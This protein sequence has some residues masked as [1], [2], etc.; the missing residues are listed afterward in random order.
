MSKRSSARDL[1]SRFSTAARRAYSSIPGLT[2]RNSVGI[3]GPSQLPRPSAIPNRPKSKGTAHIT[4]LIEFLTKTNFDGQIS[5]KALQSPSQR[6]VFSIFSHIMSCFSANF[7]IPQEKGELEDYFINTLKLF[8][9]PIPL[10]RSTVQTPGAPH[11]ASQIL[12]S[13]DWLRAEL[14]S[15][16]EKQDEIF[17]S[18]GNESVP[19]SKIIF[20]M[21]RKC[22]EANSPDPPLQVREEFEQ[23]IAHS[24]GCRPEDVD[25]LRVQLAELSNKP[26]LSTLIQEE[27]DLRSNLASIERELAEQNDRLHQLKNRIPEAEMKANGSAANLQ[28]IRSQVGETATEVEKLENLIASQRA[29]Y[30]DIVN[31]YQN[32]QERYRNRCA[33]R[34]DLLRQL[35]GRSIELVRMDKPVAPALDEYN[36]LAVRMSDSSLPQLKMRTYLHTFDALKEIPIIC[37]ELAEVRTKLAALAEKSHGESAAKRKEVESIQTECA[38]KREQVAKLEHDLEESS[39]E[40]EEFQRQAAKRKEAFAHWLMETEVAIDEARQSALAKKENIEKLQM[41]IQQNKKNYEYY[42]DL[43]RKMKVYCENYEKESVELLRGVKNRLEIKAER[44]KAEE[45]ALMEVILE[46]ESQSSQLTNQYESLL[47][48]VKSLANRMSKYSK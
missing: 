41:E 24:F 48:D 28:E 25:E 43:N 35:D 6:L 21:Y 32:L 20:N 23:E 8:G 45:T 16:A 22:V 12:S 19:A 30:G 29:Q 37:S 2:D 44:R 42:L 36:S 38:N 10:K 17:L 47:E 46:L 3:A 31:A 1:N 5:L 26:S 18:E 34:D 15:S 7:Y 4:N 11:S 40:Y 33:V 27:R 14:S 39:R 13:L 9:C